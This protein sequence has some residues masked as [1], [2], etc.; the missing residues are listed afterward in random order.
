MTKTKSSQRAAD[1]EAIRATVYLP[2]ALHRKLTDAH[3]DMR[4]ERKNSGAGGRLSLSDVIIEACSML[5]ADRAAKRKA[6]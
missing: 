3:R 5:L 1:P 6:A 2:K 4:I